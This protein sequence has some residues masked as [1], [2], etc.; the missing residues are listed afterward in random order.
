MYWLSPCNIYTSC[1]TQIN[2]K[3]ITDLNRRA[4]TIKLKKK[5]LKNPTPW[6]RQRFLI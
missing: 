1:H 4:K 6:V 2:L 5:T 3:E